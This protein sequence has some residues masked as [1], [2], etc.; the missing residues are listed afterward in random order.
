MPE[1]LA[2]K[3]VKTADV[4]RWIEKYGESNALILLSR[5]LRAHGL[6]DIEKLEAFVEREEEATAQ[7]CP[8]DVLVGVRCDQCEEAKG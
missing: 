7:Y 4:L 5:L 6:D 8:H 1:H 2:D 3:L